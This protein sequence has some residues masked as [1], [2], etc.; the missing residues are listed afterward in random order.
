MSRE[1]KFKAWDGKQMFEPRTIDEIIRYVQIPN[2][3]WL[4]FT[5]LKDKNGVD[6]YEGDIVIASEPM[7]I[8]GNKGENKK[9][10]TK[11]HLRVVFHDGHWGIRKSLSTRLIP[12]KSVT[13]RISG[14]TVI[15]NIYQNTE[16]LPK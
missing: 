7:S 3:L 8:T 15:G 11:K 12:I 6:I 4:Q 10:A 1:L 9:I 2:L 14:L 16:L 5:G 13:I